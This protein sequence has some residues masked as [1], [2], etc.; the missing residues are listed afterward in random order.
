MTEPAA[1]E[2]ATIEPITTEPTIIESVAADPT[3]TVDPK[4]VGN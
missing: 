2:P 4:K 3:T 1:I